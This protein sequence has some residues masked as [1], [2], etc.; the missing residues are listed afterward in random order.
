MASVVVVDDEPDI[1]L[2]VESVLTRAGHCVRVAVDRA[3]ALGLVDASEPDVVLC[4]LDLGGDD[5][6]E[7]L[8]WVVQHHPRVRCVLMSGYLA[9][10]RT[11]PAVRLLP[12]PFT[13]TALLELVD[14]LAGSP[15]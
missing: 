12:K 2:L 7:V 3:G 9:P 15:G 13:L 1:G 11:P 6:I 14:D 5:G 10:A 4:D 8:A